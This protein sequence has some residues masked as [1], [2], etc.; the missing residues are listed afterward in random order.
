MVGAGKP[1]PITQQIQETYFG[2]VRGEVDRYK[3]WLDYVE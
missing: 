3:D 1:G 2:A